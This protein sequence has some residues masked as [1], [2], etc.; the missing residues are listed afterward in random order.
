MLSA[1][2]L[3]THYSYIWSFVA[4]VVVV[5]VVHDS[6]CLVKATEQLEVI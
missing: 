5:V 2:S 6:L 4:V 1:V 3:S